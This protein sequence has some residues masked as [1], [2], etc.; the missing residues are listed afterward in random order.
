MY[1]KFSPGLFLE[2]V[3][4]ERFR[5]SLDEKG[6][7]LLLLNNTLK[8]GLIDK[9]Y[10][11]TNKAVVDPFNNGKVYESAGLS[12]AHNELSAIDKNG[13]FIY[14]AATSNISVPG[15][16]NW[17]WVKIKHQ[18]T[19]KEL[20][21]FS[22]DDRGNLT[23]DSASE[24][25]SILRGQPYFPSRVKFTN[26]ISNTLEYDVLEV[27]D[28]SHAILQ[29]YFVAESDLSLS[30]VG[31]FAPGTIATSDEKEIFQYDDCALT[32]IQETTLNTPPSKLEGEEFY[33]AR[34]KSDNIELTIQDKRTEKWET[35]SDFFLQD[36]E[37][38]TN[39]LL[40]VER[41][42]YDHS[43]STK[44]YNI[45]DIAWGMR[46]ENWSVNT[47]LN[48]VTFSSGQGGRYKDVTYFN[49][50]DFDGWRLY[51]QDGSFSNIIS[52]IKNGNQ[53]NL[54]LDHLDIDKVSDNGGVTFNSGTLIA[55]P[56]AEEIEITLTPYINSGGE[57][58]PITQTYVFPIN[59]GKGLC[60]ALVFSDPSCEYEITY[61]YKR[62]SSYSATITMTA[63]N[64]FGYYTEKA[65]DADG[66]ILPVVQSQS[67][68]LNLSQGYIALYSSNIIVLTLKDD[69]YIKQIEKID[70]GDVL[71]VET[72]PITLGVNDITLSVGTSRNYQ[73]V[74]DASAL[75]L[76]DNKRIILSNGL[77]NGNTFFLHFKQQLDLAGFTF[78][79][80]DATFNTL[81]N[82]STRDI[83]FLNGS[84]Q[85]IFIQCIWDGTKWILNSLNETPHIDST[86]TNS[87][88][89]G[90][91][92]TGAFTYYATDLIG[93]AT[94]TDTALP[95]SNYDRI[96]S[97]LTNASGSGTTDVLLYLENNVG[98]NI[99]V[100]YAR[101]ST[102]NSATMHIP[103]GCR[104]KIAFSSGS[105]SILIE[106]RMQKFNS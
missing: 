19:S 85:G 78:R 65:F 67:H 89:I 61:R 48:Q 30:I 27:I 88:A 17:Y 71:G 102:K 47:K 66:Y 5:K 55:A 95:A 87:W 34:V 18:Y 16:S 68:A 69:A 60:R 49:D 98:S 100:T 15:D 74:Y 81:K 86:Y 25:L 10:F 38:S 103:A 45:L 94:T 72:Q 54:T 28:D 14:K 36:I 80:V 20:G 91:T 106:C 43:F 104:Y 29:G 41:V 35:K 59:T 51:W 12:I 23:G 79:I 7:R 70:L 50:G 33:L 76:N 44:D 26:S 9:Q 93:S 99:F 82:F 64:Q 21:T 105:E 58:E 3:E 32:L 40:G 6:F 83:N 56:N 52:S 22:I 8:F 77:K 90:Y 97:I 75:T 63:D 11:N 31:T 4:L 2:K 13:N 53:I 37:K 57:P 73:Y 84:S 39:P 92:S 62:E 101:A 1:T 42:R 46:S 96:L 24:L